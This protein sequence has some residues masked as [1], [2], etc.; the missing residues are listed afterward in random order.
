MG[1]SYDYELIYQQVHQMGQQSI[2]AY[3]QQ[4]EAEPIRFDKHFAPTCFREHSYRYD[5]YDSKYETLKYTHPK[6]VAIVR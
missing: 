6:N 2:I 5:S 3:N 1:A 4:N